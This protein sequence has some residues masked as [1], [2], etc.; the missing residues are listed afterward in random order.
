MLISAGRAAR[1]QDRGIL[2]GAVSNQGPRPARSTGFQ[3]AVAARMVLLGRYEML[4]GW[5]WRRGS[6]SRGHLRRWLVDA[7]ALALLSGKVSP[8]M[9]GHP[10]ARSITRPRFSGGAVVHQLQDACGPRTFQQGGGGDQRYL[11]ASVVQAENCARGQSAHEQAGVKRLQLRLRGKSIPGTQMRGGTPCGRAAPHA[12]QAPS[13]TRPGL[14][15]R[16]SG[17]APPAVPCR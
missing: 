10:P 2:A 7:P 13:L 16:P 5:R 4:A 15:Q 12:Q 11:R 14:V 9:S 6:A 3:I 8:P 1:H 17:S